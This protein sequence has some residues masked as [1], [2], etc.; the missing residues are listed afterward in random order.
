[1]ARTFAW[2]GSMNLH[3]MVMLPATP[4]MMKLLIDTRAS[5]T[6]VDASLGCDPVPLASAYGFADNVAC[7]LDAV[8]T[9]GIDTQSRLG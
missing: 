3:P 4:P 2:F 7:L 8:P 1:M 9:Y 6:G 5:V